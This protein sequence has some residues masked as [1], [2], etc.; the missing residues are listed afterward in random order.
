MDALSSGGDIPD[1]E[2]RGDSKKQSLVTRCVIYLATQLVALFFFVGFPALTTWGAP[3]SWLHFERHGDGVSAT[4]KTCLFF[5]LP[6]RTQVVDPVLGIGD[7]TVAG[8]VRRERRPGRDKVVQAED[9]GYLVIQGDKQSAE[10]LVTPFN[11][12]DVEQRC[13]DFLEDPTAAEL[14][15]FVVANWKFSVVMGGLLS[16]LTVIYCG[17]IGFGL[18][19][20]FI[21]IV[22]WAAGVPPE[23]RLFARLLKESKLRSASGNA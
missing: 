21:H 9:K 11:L 10:V 17:T 13:N 6:Y 3:V 1:R 19:L 18:V 23:K 8:T 5:I 12:K 2:S 15:L 20:K 4:A 22:Q 14:K 16:L 7:R